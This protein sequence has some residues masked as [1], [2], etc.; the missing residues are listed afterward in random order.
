[1]FG[2]HINMKRTISYKMQHSKIHLISFPR[3]FYVYIHVPFTEFRRSCSCNGCC[4]FDNARLRRQHVAHG[5]HMPTNT[6][7]TS[8]SSSGSASDNGQFVH[9]VLLFKS[10]G[11]TRNHNQFACVVGKDSCERPSILVSLSTHS[12]TAL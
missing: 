11:C 1:M 12:N 3:C 10:A 2:A 5:I 4:R 7:Q 6:P 9:G 8:S